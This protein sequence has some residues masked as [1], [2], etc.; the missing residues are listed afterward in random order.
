VIFYTDS[1]FPLWAR[2]LITVAAVAAF[3]VLAWQ[4]YVRYRKKR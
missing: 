3:G 1:S 4:Y 2:L